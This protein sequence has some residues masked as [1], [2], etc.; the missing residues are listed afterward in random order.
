VDRSESG[1]VPQ[2]ANGQ[3]V[4]IRST[5]WLGLG[6]ITILMVME[7]RSVLISLNPIVSVQMDADT[8]ITPSLPIPKLTMVMGDIIVRLWRA[9]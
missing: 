9:E 2:N 5:A 1:L 8:T 4:A 3:R 7:N 6:V